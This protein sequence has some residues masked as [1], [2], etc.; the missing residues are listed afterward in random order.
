MY[1][2]TYHENDTDETVS[3]GC[4]FSA[5][6]R[7]LSNLKTL[8]KVS[9]QPSHTIPSLRVCIQCIKTIVE[10][11]ALRSTPL[12]VRKLVRVLMCLNPSFEVPDDISSR[13]ER[14]STNSETNSETDKEE[15]PSLGCLGNIN[16]WM[17][18]VLLCEHLATRL[19]EF[20][21]EFDDIE[22]NTLPFLNTIHAIAKLQ[23]YATEKV[24]N[25]SDEDP[26]DINADHS[27][28]GTVATLL[29]ELCLELMTDGWG[30]LEQ[31]GDCT[32]NKPLRVKSSVLRTII[33]MAFEHCPDRYSLT[34]RLVSDEITALIATDGC[35]GPVPSLLTLHKQ[36][37]P[38]YFSQL[39]S[40]LVVLTKQLDFK[41]ALN[42]AAKQ[43]SVLYCMSRI[44][45]WMQTLVLLT[46]IEALAGKPLFLCATLKKCPTSH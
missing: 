46:K 6:A 29:S 12:M 38:C 25:D 16:P 8:I 42:N 10:C 13:N 24:R 34:D 31:S 14:V 27:A 45:S 15:H 23:N 7:T 21:H 44:A 22:L 30:D 9:P 37:F 36:T 2:E 11:Q 40:N 28:H 4:T 17:G 35:K 43:K 3:M 20:I 18:L 19:G 32:P 33:M 1:V 39:L 5:L 41:N 26:C